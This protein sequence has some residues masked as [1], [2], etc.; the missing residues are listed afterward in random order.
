APEITIDL[1]GIFRG[2]N[3]AENAVGRL[4]VAG[5]IV[6]K[7]PVV[8]V[9]IYGILLTAIYD[10]G[11]VRRSLLVP[12]LFCQVGGR[13]DVFG[14][15]F[16]HGIPLDRQFVISDRRQ[17]RGGIGRLGTDIGALSIV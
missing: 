12:Q 1:R 7:S 10:I 13:S 17:L 5:G 14:F 15:E 4:I 6:G 8:E 3:T 2:I 11:Q 9:R 16:R